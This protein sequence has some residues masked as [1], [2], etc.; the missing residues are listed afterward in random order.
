MKKQRNSS[1]NQI[2]TQINTTLDA[3][4]SRKLLYTFNYIYKKERENNKWILS[5]SNHE[6]GKFNTGEY[7]LKLEQYKKI[8]RNNSYLCILYD[9]SLIRVSY[10]FQN[11]ILLGHNLLW[12]PAPYAYPNVTIDDFSPSELMEEFLND[13]TWHEVLNMRSPVRIDFDPKVASEIHPAT[14][15][16]MQ[17][18]DCRMYVE[19]PLCFNRFINFILKNNYPNLRFDFDDY[20]YIYFELPSNLETF[21]VSN[22]GIII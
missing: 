9:G 7:F 5:W 21:D 16:H 17:H 13:L 14:H 15:I 4:N 3:L 12:W 18:K 11:N 8:I 22:S 10:T 20:D 1:V 19:K 2:E 6:S